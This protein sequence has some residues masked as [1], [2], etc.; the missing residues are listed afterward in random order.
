MS[1]GPQRTPV[2]REPQSQFLA[3]GHTPHLLPAGLQ[4][5]RALQLEAMA[6][7]PKQLE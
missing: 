7:V 5:C 3:D 2:P 4:A 6:T 1:L